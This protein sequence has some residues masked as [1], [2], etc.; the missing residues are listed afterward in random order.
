MGNSLCPAKDEYL[1]LVYNTRMPEPP[2]QRI[3][4]GYLRVSVDL[5]VES[6]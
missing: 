3:Q 1:A 6:P 4:Q 5:K 2:R